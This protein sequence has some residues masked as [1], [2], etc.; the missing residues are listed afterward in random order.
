M[1]LL[2]TV[3]ASC[4]PACHEDTK[5]IGSNVRA[6]SNYRQ[7]SPKSKT[8]NLRQCGH[9][10]A[11]S[12]DAAG[13]PPVLET[14]V[15]RDETFPGSSLCDNANHCS[16]DNCTGL[17]NRIRGLVRKVMDSVEPA[18]SSFIPGRPGQW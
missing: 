1:D 12:R 8:C 14:D 2:I 10:V 15:N 7:N 16:I 13:L 17:L 3:D 9:K 18:Q 6:A 11:R 5:E 4:S